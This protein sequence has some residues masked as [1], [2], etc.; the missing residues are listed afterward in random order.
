MQRK[1]AAHPM[2]QDGAA[3]KRLLL[4]EDCRVKDL[5]RASRG[6]LDG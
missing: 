4:C 2:F 3:L 5:F 6:R 1:L